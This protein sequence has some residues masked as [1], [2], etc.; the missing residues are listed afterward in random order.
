[1]HNLYYNFRANHPVYLSIIIPYGT[2]NEPTSIAGISHLVEH[3]LCKENSKFTDLG[4]L[5]NELAIRGMYINAHTSLDHIRLHM[6]IPALSDFDFGVSLLEAMLSG[7]SYAEKRI[8][9]EKKAISSEISLLK[10]TPSK[11]IYNELLRGIFGWKNGLIPNYGSERTLAKIRLNHVETY[12][13]AIRSCP[14]TVIGAGGIDKYVFNKAF[15]NLLGDKTQLETLDKTISKKVQRVVVKTELE[16][17]GHSTIGLAIKTSPA[18]LKELA[19][20][21]IL[22]EYLGNYV[23]GKITQKLRDESGDVYYFDAG[24]AVYG[25]MG[26]VNFCTSAEIQKTSKIYGLIEAQIELLSNGKIDLKHFEIVKQMIL[27]RSIVTLEQSSG[28]VIANERLKEYINSGKGDYIKYL[29]K[30]ERTTAHNVVSA[31]TLLSSSL[32]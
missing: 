2:V 5:K 27:K 1:M 15:I 10:N 26:I 29:E 8:E 19:A 6:G 13:K 3:L 30:V 7:S 17:G 25:K 18:S 20:L 22:V 4:E 24:H 32:I 9:L 14:V 31:A 11:F 28:E 16:A 23:F 12:F 21:D